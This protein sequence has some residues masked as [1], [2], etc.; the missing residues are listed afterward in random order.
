MSSPIR[1]D[2]KDLIP[3]TGEYL[4][5]RG[6]VGSGL[7]RA[8]PREARKPQANGVLGVE[9]EERGGLCCVKQFGR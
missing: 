3:R 5:E 9:V 6:A 8:A 4:W 2:A 7:R 1:A